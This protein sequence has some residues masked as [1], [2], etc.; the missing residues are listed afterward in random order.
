MQKLHARVAASLSG[1]TE[2]EWAPVVL[3][4]EEEEKEDEEDMLMPKILA[5]TLPRRSSLSRLLRR[6]LCYL[7]VFR[8][9]CGG[10]LVPVLLLL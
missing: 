4:C 3:L 7:C 2:A 6:S 10:D 8:R 5:W 9:Y 1:R